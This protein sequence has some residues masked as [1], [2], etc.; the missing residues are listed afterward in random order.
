MESRHSIKKG[1]VT[2]GVSS[3]KNVDR[4]GFMTS[5][6]TNIINESSKDFRAKY[7]EKI[8]E[9]VAGHMSGLPGKLGPNS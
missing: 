8:K 9:K 7:E 4:L 1:E 3:R 2:P 6:F 5:K